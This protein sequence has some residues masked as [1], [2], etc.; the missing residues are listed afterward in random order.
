M[1]RV[2]G[3]QGIVRFSAS[4]PAASYNTANGLA[5]LFSNTIGVDNTAN[6]SQ[7]LYKNTTGVENTANGSFALYSNTTGAENTANGLQALYSNST[8][9]DNTANGSISKAARAT[10]A[11]SP[12]VRSF[13]WGCG[14]T[15]TSSVE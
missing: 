6:G 11:L 15:D 12:S 2:C 9:Y 13:P 10:I 4:P 3:K 5:A 1:G 8:G 14:R 7:A